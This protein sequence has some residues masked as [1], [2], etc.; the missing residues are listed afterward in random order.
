MTRCVLCNSYY[1][2]F[3][4]RSI[5]N[6]CRSEFIA[7]RPSGSTETPEDYALAKL[8]AL[9]EMER[10][11]HRKT[12]AALQKAVHDRDR[13]KRYI[14]KIQSTASMC[15]PKRRKMSHD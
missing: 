7:R 10:N 12:K 4:Q 8:S 13:Y 14:K 5:C 3:G 11:E 1:I 9:L 2:S 15:A 6:I